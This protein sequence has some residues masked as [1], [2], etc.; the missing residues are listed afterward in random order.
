MQR[1]KPRPLFVY[2]REILAVLDK[3]NIVT[4]CLILITIQIE[5]T[6]VAFT[7]EWDIND[8]WLFKSITAGRYLEQTQPFDFDGI[9]I[10]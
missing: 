10:P 6:T 8:Q 5:Q 9:G 1:P 4:I 3:L 2:Y 7:A